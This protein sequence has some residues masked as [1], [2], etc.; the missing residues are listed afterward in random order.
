MRIFFQ[1]KS[2]HSWQSLC[3]LFSQMTD[4]NDLSGPIPA[5]IGKLTSLDRLW[6]RT[7]TWYESSINWIHHISNN[8]FAFSFRKWQTTTSWRAA[9]QL[10]SATWR[11]PFRVDSAS[12]LPVVFVR[13]A[14]FAYCHVSFWKS[15]T[16]IISVSQCVRISQTIRKMV[17]WVT[18]TT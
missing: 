15:S 1:L 11:V 8:H 16:H 9:F 7:W 10:S 4:D 3:F 17:L 18:L 5:E 6:L 14:W 12:L 2:S 13:F